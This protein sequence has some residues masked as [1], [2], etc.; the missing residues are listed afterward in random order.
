[1]DPA[2]PPLAPAK[3]A[4]TSTGLTGEEA[5]QRLEKF[6]PNTVADTSMHPSA[7]GPGEVLGAGS[8]DAGGGDCA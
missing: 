3:D 6:G 4:P 2:T 8:V 1:M 7:A 5:R